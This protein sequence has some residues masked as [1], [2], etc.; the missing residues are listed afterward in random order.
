MAWETLQRCKGPL[1][2]R[3]TFSNRHVL[4]CSCSSCVIGA[5]SISTR[6]ASQESSTN[7]DCARVHRL[8]PALA[9]AN[10][11]GVSQLSAEPDNGETPM[12]TP[13]TKDRRHALP[14]V[15]CY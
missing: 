2:S 12:P 5:T 14:I 11:G 9:P 7:P 3:C 1:L 13:P 15:T 6:R 8:D 10:A 4:L